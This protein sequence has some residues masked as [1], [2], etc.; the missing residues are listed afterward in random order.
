MFGIEST[1]WK[2][3]IWFRR[4]VFISNLISFSFVS[5]Y[6]LILRDVHRIRFERFRLSFNHIL[7]KRFVQVLFTCGSLTKKMPTSLLTCNVNEFWKKKSASGSYIE[8]NCKLIEIY[9]VGMRKGTNKIFF[10]RKEQY[11]WN[12]WDKCNGAKCIWCANYRW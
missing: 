8:K 10:E 12:F 7:L 4:Y 6:I 9:R 11:I 3:K 2:N 5:L 1:R